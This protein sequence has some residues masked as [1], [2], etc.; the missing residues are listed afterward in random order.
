[1]IQLINLTHGISI[2]GTIFP[3]NTLSFGIKNTTIIYIS[4]VSDNSK[5]FS[6]DY[7]DFIDSSHNKYVSAQ[8]VIDALTLNNAG[9][10]GGGIWGTI[11]GTLSDQTDLQ[12]ALTTLSTRAT[13]LETH[14][15]KVA[16]FASVNA[17]SGA[18]TPPTGATILLNEFQAGISAYVSTIVNG[19]PTG[20]FPKTAGGV[21]VDVT[22]FDALGNYVL[23]GTPSAYPVALI[24]KFSISSINYDANVIQLNVLDIETF[25]FGYKAGDV[26]S[27]GTD[28]AAS[29]L[30][31]TDAN[32]KLQPL[33][34]GTY[35]S[36]TEISYVKNVTSALQTQIDGKQSL[37]GYTAENIT[38]KDTDGTLFANS[39]IKYPSQ[40]ATKTYADTKQAA[41][42]F[43][44][45]NISNKATDFS[46]LNNTL[47]PTTQAVNN[48]IL[49]QLATLDSKPDVQYASTSA[50]PSN[51][52]S[53]GSSGVGATLTGTANGPLIIDSVTILIGQVGQRVLVA[54]EAAPANNGW[55]TITQVGVVAVS[56]YILTRATE[57][58]Q[59]VEIGAGYLTGV[60]A[61]NS[62]TPGS[63]NNGK[64]FISIAADP[65]TVGTTSLT[66]SAVGGTYTNGNGI[67]LSGSTFSIDTSVTVD[68]T[69]AQTLSNKYIL[70]AKS[71]NIASSGTTD[72]STATGNLIHITGVTTITAFG[73]VQAGACYKLVFDG[74]LL[75]TYNATSLILP[76][77]VNITTAANDTCIIESEGSGNWRVI[78]YTRNVMAT[79]VTDLGLST[80]A[81]LN[82]GQIGITYTGQGGVVGINNYVE[83]IIPYACTINNW[84]ISSVNP[85]D[86]TAVSGSI[87]IDIKR[88]GS[89]IIG[90]GNKPTLSSASANNASVSGWTSV[91][92]AANDKLAFYV[93]SATTVTNIECI[94]NT[95]KT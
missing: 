16:Y 18:I 38:N 50:L 75:L 60:V 8:A 23:T 40:K 30:V 43:T 44:P 20:I 29:E 47:Y 72:L 13:N 19:Q 46:V 94:I 62:V 35:P 89:S 45:E 86:G 64:V 12:T 53:N 34:I 79:R 54:G 11:T 14:A 65:F 61:S 22:S 5:V 58:D 84:Y 6:I 63:L 68:K 82:I 41:L 51:T 39:D 37:L 31:A 59:A 10:S 95:T 42:G 55:Y 69:T 93:V 83:V 33:D 3:N 32:R 92:V 26:V 80:A 21:E 81:S 88:S 78:D 52:Y 90:G 17:S 48:Q 77:A 85:L 1:M 66:F 24:Y 70:E 87:V 28:L 7:T 74:I 15:L 36:L 25:R 67:S 76:G 73:T 4:L 27:I 57:S 71:A 49:A 56:K 91:A 2:N 9:G